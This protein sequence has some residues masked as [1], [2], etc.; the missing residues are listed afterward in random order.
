[1]KNKSV[2]WVLI[3]G[4]LIMVSILIA[5]TADITLEIIDGKP[6]MKH[7]LDMG[8]ENCFSCH[9]GG[10][11]QVPAAYADMPIELCAS[12]AC[13]I[14]LSTTTPTTTP[15]TIP[16]TTP[17]S[18]PPTTTREPGEPPPLTAPGHDLY[19]ATGG[20]CLT[21]HGEQGAEE[22]RFPTEGPYDHTGRT[23]EECLTTEGCHVL[24]ME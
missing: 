16:T 10:L 9:T 24:A 6:V 14:L 5:C 8:Y 18:T 22:D 1:M 11:Y 12:P 15:T 4:L 20:L 3:A 13:H 7:E 17:T 2:I 21:C 23:D 19:A